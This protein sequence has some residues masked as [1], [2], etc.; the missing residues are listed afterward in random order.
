MIIYW[1]EKFPSEMQS[2]LQ[3]YMCVTRDVFREGERERG[4]TCVMLLS[5]LIP[6]HVIVDRADEIQQMNKHT[7]KQLN[8]NTML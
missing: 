4:R 6:R 3:A 5:L 8:K 2:R 7:T 1:L